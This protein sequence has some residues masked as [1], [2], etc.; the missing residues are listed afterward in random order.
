M[1]SPHDSAKLH[2]KVS[3]MEAA[4]NNRLSEMASSGEELKMKEVALQEANAIAHKATALMHHFRGQAHDLQRQCADW[5]QHSSGGHGGVPPAWTTMPEMGA[6][7]SSSAPAPSAEG[8]GLPLPQL[9]NPPPPRQHAPSA[10]ESSSQAAAPPAPATNAPQSSSSSSVRRALALD[11]VDDPAPSAAPSAV[12]TATRAALSAISALAAPP[13]EDDTGAPGTPPMRL[14]EPPPKQ[15][16]ASGADGVAQ[17]NALLRHTRVPP[18]ASGAP[19]N[20][21]PNPMTPR[22]AGA[23]AAVARGHPSGPVASTI[24]VDAI[25]SREATVSSR[26]DTSNDEAHTPRLIGARAS[27]TEAERSANVAIAAAMATPRLA[28]A[29]VNVAGA[30]DIGPGDDGASAVALPNLL[31]VAGFGGG[32]DGALEAKNRELTTLRRALHEAQTAEAAARAEAK[33]ALRFGAREQAAAAA[34]T[35]E[36]A[37]ATSAAD[38]HAA[39]MAKMSSQLE[40]WRARESGGVARADSDAADAV[41]L[42]AERLRIIADKEE[43]IRTKEHELLLLADREAAATKLADEVRDL[44][45][46]LPSPPVPTVCP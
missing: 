25:S 41:A 36:L 10:P 9:R 3:E 14:P 40:W 4:L 17:L 45:Y 16:V 30:L 20:H 28:G 31:P 23:M 8:G 43:E 29:L 5:Q 7:A 12:S 2:D 46:G 21:A 15:A 19:A 42:A 44:A 1:T 35:T 34:A 38:A 6:A 18:S 27:A 24:D 37:A 13:I 11:A 22:M 33:D 39:Q 26:E 32:A